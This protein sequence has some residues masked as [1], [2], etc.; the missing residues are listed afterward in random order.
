MSRA[1]RRRRNEDPRIVTAPILTMMLSLTAAVQQVAIVQ[2]RQQPRP[3]VERALP[4][5]DVSPLAA[6]AVVEATRSHESGVQSRPVSSAR[7]LRFH[8]SELEAQQASHTSP[9]SGATTRWRENDFR[10]QWRSTTL[11]HRTDLH[12]IPYCSA[13][14]VYRE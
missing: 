1:R 7:P 13:V 8:A 3:L 12:G 10:Q 6:L 5:S 14:C 11:R 9:E 2:L 4:A